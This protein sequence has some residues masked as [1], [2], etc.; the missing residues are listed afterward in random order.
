MLEQALLIYPCVVLP[1]IGAFVVE[2]TPPMYD[3]ALNLITPSGSEVSFHADL[4]ERDGI[5]DSYYARLMGLSVRRA[6]VIVDQ[7][8]AV[9]RQDLYQAGSISFATLGRLS[10]QEGGGLLFVPDKEGFIST[11]SYGLFPQPCLLPSVAAVKPAGAEKADKRPVRS[12][13]R[14]WTLRIN[15]T[16]ANWVAAIAVC[17][18]C[19]L[20]VSSDSYKERYS[21]GFVPFAWM[22]GNAGAQSS[23]PLV[24]KEAC[25]EREGGHLSPDVPAPTEAVLLDRDAAGKKASHLVVAAVFKTKHRAEQCID[26][27]RASLPDSVPAFSLV[28]DR[29]RFL[30]VA[31]MADS[32]EEAHS[33]R[34][35]TARLGGEL[36][37]AWVYALK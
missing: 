10:I 25:S 27:Y 19:L 29:G 17:I 36:A 21:A 6:R 2:H 30:V 14:Y 35:E 1:T 20:P 31:G 22:D 12:D 32:E 37:N 15:R 23:A 18:L 3:K 24:V 13:N 4:T 5:L 7:D 26:A 33:M 28:D 34:R 16:A 8:A 11:H 9:L